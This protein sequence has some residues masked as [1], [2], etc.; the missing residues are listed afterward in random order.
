MLNC[1]ALRSLRCNKFL[2]HAQRT[3]HKICINVGIRIFD[4]VLL[5]ED[6]T[7]V[8]NYFRHLRYP[9]TW[10]NVYVPVQLLNVWII[11][12]AGLMRF[13]KGDIVQ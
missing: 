2:V 11:V 12:H 7:S 13:H 9:L 10:K 6:N 3:M 8:I 4:P 5:L 1:V